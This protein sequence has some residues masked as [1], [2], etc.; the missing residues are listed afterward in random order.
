MIVVYGK[1]VVPILIHCP[2]Y[3]AAAEGIWFSDDRMVETRLIEEIPL[4][5]KVMSILS[6]TIGH[7]LHVLVAPPTM[8]SV[9]DYDVVVVVIIDLITDRTG[10][11]VARAAAR[12]GRGAVVG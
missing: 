7:N 10:V 5:R 3:R 11:V 12:G 2:L 9:V 8:G 1:V 4:N 6:G